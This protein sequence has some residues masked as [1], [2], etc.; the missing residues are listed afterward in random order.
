MRNGSSWMSRRVALVITDLSE[1]NIFSQRSSVASYGYV[2][3]SS[4]ILVTMMM[5]T[6]RSSE[7]SVLARAI[8]RNIQEDGILYKIV[9]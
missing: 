8:R 4:T 1:K 2:V 9:Y 6:L 5:E 7:T 3:T